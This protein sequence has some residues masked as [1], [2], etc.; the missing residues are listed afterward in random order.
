M[1][2]ITTSFLK[3]VL[4]TLLS[5]PPAHGSTNFVLFRL[6]ITNEISFVETGM[7]AFVVSSKKSVCSLLIIACFIKFERKFITSGNKTEMNPE[8]DTIKCVLI[9]DK[10]RPVNSIWCARNE[11]RH[12]RTN[13]LHIRKQRRR[14][15]SR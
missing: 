6:K 4:F 15:A 14:S 12:E 9:G 8:T 2:S 13:V 3:N 11:P 1:T 7:A 10:K 5:D